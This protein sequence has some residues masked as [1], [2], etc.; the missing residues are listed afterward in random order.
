MKPAGALLAATVLVALAAV[1]V[2]A[3]F[4]PIQDSNSGSEPDLWSVLDNV[5]P[6]G[7][8]SSWTSTAALNNNTSGLRVLDRPDS[9]GDTFDQIWADGRVSVTAT[10]LYWGGAANPADTDNQVLIW[11]DWPGMAGPYTTNVK[12]G[13]MGTSDTIDM[14]AFAKPT[15]ILGDDSR[16]YADAW[17]KESLNTWNTP[18]GTSDRM[19]TFDVAGLDIYY[20]DTSTV[21]WTKLKTAGDG[22]YM[23]CFDPGADGDF[24]DLIVLV[25]DA[26][27]VPAPGAIVLGL[28]GLGAVGVWMRRYA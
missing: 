24:Q 21:G 22:A 18:T 14:T 8:G 20:W 28:M 15:F 1:P 5:A 12:V 25:E 13:T 19:V 11:D 9:A 2:L 3:D 10:A 26:H 27:P 23:V 6:L 17:S 16:S 4:T 7:G